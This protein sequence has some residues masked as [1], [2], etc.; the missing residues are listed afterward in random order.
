MRQK[1]QIFS[2]TWDK[3]SFVAQPVEGFYYDREDDLFYDE[4]G[5]YYGIVTYILNF[6]YILKFFKNDLMQWKQ[7]IEISGTMERAPNLLR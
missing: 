2:E 3:E 7:K 1:K 6:I 5:F 4:D